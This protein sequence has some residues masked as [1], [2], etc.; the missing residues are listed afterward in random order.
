V[1]AKLWDPPYARR[2]TRRTAKL[3]MKEKCVSVTNLETRVAIPIIEKLFLN[4]KD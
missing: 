1:K 3:R 4:I 2:T